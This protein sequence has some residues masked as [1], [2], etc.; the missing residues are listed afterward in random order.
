MATIFTDTDVRVAAD[1]WAYSQDPNDVGFFAITNQRSGGVSGG[2][3]VP[4]A[5]MRGDVKLEVTHRFGDFS[6]RVAFSGGSYVAGTGG[7][8]Y[9]GGLRFQ[10][11]FTRSFRLWLTLGARHDVD[12]AGTDSFSRS[13]SLGAGLRF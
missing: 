8:T 7:G 4:I 5:P 12:A 9:G 2:G 6:A 13:G 11:K 10:Y 3:G 1:A